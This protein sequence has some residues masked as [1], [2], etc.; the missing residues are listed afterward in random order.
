MTTNTVHTVGT[1]PA[2]VLAQEATMTRPNRP[3][4][5]AAGGTALLIAGTLLSTTLGT[6]SASAPAAP[7]KSE[8]RTFFTSLNNSGVRGKAEAEGASGST[9]ATGS[10][11]SPVSRSR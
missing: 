5:Y 10:I 9:I 3:K 2:L 6:A 1:V 7:G 8:T 4:L 11:S